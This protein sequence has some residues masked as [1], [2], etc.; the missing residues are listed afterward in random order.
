MEK[1]AV[2]VDFF[3]DSSSSFI[4]SDGKNHDE[5]RTH[6]H[7]IKKVDP[8]VS[9][10]LSD[11]FSDNS[12]SISSTSNSDFQQSECHST[13]HQSEAKHKSETKHKSE[14][15]H[16]NSKHDHLDKNWYNEL[17]KDTKERFGESTESMNP[18]ESAFDE[19]EINFTDFKR[20][21]KEHYSKLKNKVS[22]KKTP[23]KNDVKRQP[24][25]TKYDVWENEVDRTKQ[26]NALDELK[27][28]QKQELFLMKQSMQTGKGNMEQNSAPKSNNSNNIKIGQLSESFDRM[29]K[30]KLTINKEIPKKSTFTPTKF[31]GSM[32][33]FNE[34]SNFDNTQ[35][36]NSSTQQ[37]MSVDSVLSKYY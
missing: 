29:K 25:T 13:F 8:P 20:K 28:K 32:S 14:S 17:E 5:L 3:S 33:N 16:K 19:S 26:M 9:M 18:S 27:K 2:L 15:K 34:S 23:S 11:F 1:S 36:I 35:M 31:D 37:S 24:Q 7:S 10:S 22:S 30:G 4:T 21:A 6:K 12:A